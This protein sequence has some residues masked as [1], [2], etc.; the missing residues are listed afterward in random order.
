MRN[1]NWQFKF[2]IYWFVAFFISAFV[3]MATQHEIAVNISLALILIIGALML[4]TN[5]REVAL[6]ISSKKWP[7]ARFS[8]LNAQVRRSTIPDGGASANYKAYFE[9][10]YQVSGVSYTL[11]CN[12]FSIPFHNSEEEAEKYIQE[13]RDGKYGKNVYYNPTRPKNAY[14]KP[15]AKFHQVIAILFGLGFVF[16]PLGFMF[17]HINV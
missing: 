9:L 7:T 6:S 17:G 14:V 5:I 4:L 13:V 12:A 15:G 10:G 11:P 1:T 8:I 16:V 3:A 2:F